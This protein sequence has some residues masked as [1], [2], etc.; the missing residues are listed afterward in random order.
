MTQPPLYLGDP[1]RRGINLPPPS[2]PAFGAVQE[3]SRAR[4]EYPPPNA[5]EGAWTSMGCDAQRV[6]I[7]GGALGTLLVHPMVESFE[8]L[9]RRLPEEGMFAP[10]VSPERPFAFELG[11]FKPPAGFDLLLFDLRPDIYRFSGVD[12]GDTVP[13]ESRRFSSILGFEITIDQKHPGN[14]QFQLDPIPIQREQQAFTPQIVPGFSGG[15]AATSVPQ[16]RF[17]IAASSS[18]SNAA[19]AGLALMPQRPTRYGPLSIPFT[20]YVRQNQTVQVRCVVFRPIP[21][22]IA[23]VEYDIAGLLLPE[24]WV[25]SL[26][27]CTKP[28]TMASG[29]PGSIGGGPR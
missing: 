24:L 15:E 11:A 19:G 3:I 8:Q 27:E 4:E 20:L 6:Q 12:P 21:S 5:V 7:A 17:D 1:R 13:V 16:S 2:P 28:L 9:Y 23:F 26:K 10:D 25:D 22:P 29:G 14:V 18:F